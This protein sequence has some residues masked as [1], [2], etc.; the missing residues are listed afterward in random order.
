MAIKTLRSAHWDTLSPVRKVELAQANNIEAWL[1]PSYVQLVERVLPLTLEEA[2][3]IGMEVT[4]IVGQAREKARSNR[5]DNPRL[6]LLGEALVETVEE[7]IRAV[8][9]S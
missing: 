5:K 1:V 2:N 4:L 9:P 3:R 6:F 8:K 7:T